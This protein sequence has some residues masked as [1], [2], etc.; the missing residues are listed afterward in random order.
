M[1]RDCRSG[2]NH[3]SRDSFTARLDNE[4]R[5]RPVAMSPRSRE[6]YAIS[7]LAA[8]YHRLSLLQPREICHSCV[9]AGIEVA[10]RWMVSP[11]GEDACT[12]RTEE[13]NG[14]LPDVYPGSSFFPICPR[15]FLP[16]YV[17]SGFFS[18]I[19]V[20]VLYV[21]SEIFKRHRWIKIYAALSR[22]LWH[23]YRILYFTILETLD[24]SIILLF[25]NIVTIFDYIRVGE[26]WMKI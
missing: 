5:A 1:H 11:G 3:L 2:K 23:F 8:A 12:L 22:H 10:A 17:P 19:P 20:R 18:L 15:I 25:F 16:F 4:V 7:H 6:R 24:L 26:V 13:F 14:W 9:R 21:S